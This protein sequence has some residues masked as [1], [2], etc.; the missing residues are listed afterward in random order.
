MFLETEGALAASYQWQ[1]LQPLSASL[2]E[3]VARL[4]KQLLGA[5]PAYA[6]VHAQHGT[7]CES[8]SGAVDGVVE[9]CQDAHAF[10]D[11]SSSE[12]DGQGKKMEIVNTRL[13]KRVQGRRSPTRRRQR[14]RL[15]RPLQWTISCEELYETR[16]CTC[17]TEGGRAPIWCL[18]RLSVDQCGR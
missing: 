8:G 11:Y 14:R 3:G 9:C 12:A 1:Q 15:F 10:P 17:R 2:L 18:W 5:P 7:S 4:P 16:E 13:K 6:L